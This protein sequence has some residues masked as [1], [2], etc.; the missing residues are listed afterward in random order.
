[1]T[2]LPLLFTIGTAVSLFL[3]GS[4]LRDSVTRSYLVVFLFI[5][6]STE[7]LSV[8]GAVTSG[9]LRLLWI[10]G[11]LVSLSVMSF[12]LLHT[13]RRA[14]SKDRLG[15]FAEYGWYEA[16][17]FLMISCILLATLTVALVY[18]PNNWDSMTYHMARVAYW[19]QNG[20]I[21]VY[22]TANDRQTHNPPLAEWAILHLQLLGHSDRF[23][24]IVQWI[25]FVVS[26]VVSTLIAQEFRLSFKA[27]WLTA[28]VAATIPTAI[29]ESSSTQNDLVVSSFCISF[30]YFLIRFTR[31]LSASDAVLCS[32]SLGLALLTKG[33]AYIYCCAIGLTI[34]VT[35]VA[36]ISPPKRLAL[37]NRLTVI[38]A[39]A[40]LLNVGHVS[41]TYLVYGLN[42]TSQTPLLN[43]EIS[44]MIIYSNL[45]RNAAL[46][47]GTPS[48]AMNAYS[49]RAIGFLLGNQTNNPRST[50]QTT[51][52]S[53]PAFSLHED[54]AGNLLHLALI[55]SAFLILPLVTI[56]NKP[57]VYCYAGSLLVGVLLHCIMLKWQPWA[58]RYHTTIFMLSA[59]FIVA[60]CSGIRPIQKQLFVGTACV[61]FAGG[62]PFLISNKT[63]SFVELTNNWLFTPGGQLESYFVNRPNISADY[64]AAANL[65]L[66]E[67]VGDVGLCLGYDDYEYPLFV[68]VGTHASQGVPRF[69]HVGVVDR[70]QI[71]ANPHLEPPALVLATKRLDE[72][73][74]HGKGRQVVDS[75]LGPDHTPIFDSPTVRMWKKRKSP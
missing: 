46:H 37:L 74:V 25:S 47:I 71:K 34:G 42:P 7:C 70:S 45:V 9:A 20:S 24:N 52:F 40:V 58:T 22:P 60:V 36:S 31:T 67:G 28:L 1:M 54:Y 26:I 3:K 2:A 30:A 68:L 8:L 55:V 15:V 56:P 48:D 35:A 39:A 14:L 73:K 32:L 49:F 27:Q 64:K 11:T 69:R 72:D 63:R 12:R 51:A 6:A 62:I 61:L 43:D 57:T 29:L 44:P 17:L 23:A 4:G 21:D 75:C 33:T 59:P 66:Q 10:V 19:I 16:L 50:L 5:V 53:I 65:I 13:D 38:V 41:R 18:P